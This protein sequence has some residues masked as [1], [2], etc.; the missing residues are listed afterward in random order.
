[1]KPPPH[2]IPGETGSEQLES[3]PGCSRALTT[4]QLLM[5][6]FEAKEWGSPGDSELRTLN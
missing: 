2:F 4:L 5:S 1:M 6:V 3:S